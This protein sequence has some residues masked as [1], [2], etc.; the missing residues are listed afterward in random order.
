MNLRAIGMLAAAAATLGAC[1]TPAGSTPPLEPSPPAETE[2]CDAE[3]A[4]SVVGQ[5]YSA[6]TAEQARAA[7]GA[8]VVRRIEPGQMVTME[9]RAGRLNIDTDA[10]GRITAVRCG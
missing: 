8:T 2:R 10:G 6:A 4:R 9:F 5:V 1:A 3:A 7:S